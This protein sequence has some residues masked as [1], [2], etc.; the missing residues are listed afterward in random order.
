MANAII[1]SIKAREIIDSRGNPTVEVDCVTDDGVFTD[2]VPSGASAGAKEAKELRDG[3]KRYGGKGVL[4]AIKNVNEVISQAIVGEDASDQAAIDNFLI[5]L[6]G[7]PDKSKLGANAILAVSMAACRA[8]AANLKIPLYEHIG[9][10]S[11][12]KDFFMPRPCFNIIN[13]GAH[14]ENGLDFQEFMIVPQKES[15]AENVQAGSETYYQLKKLI[16][17]SYSPAAAN[18]GDEG[19]FAPPMDAP[20]IALGLIT[21]AIQRSGYYDKIGII[22]DAAASQF[23]NQT[24]A[25]SYYKTMMGIFED[26]EFLNYYDELVNQYPII[27]LEDPFAEEDWESFASINKKYG[28]RIMIIGDDLLA[29]NSRYI[30]KAKTKE[31]C[32]AALLKLNQIGTVTE[33]IKSAKLAQSYG[34]KTII[35]HRSGETTDD[36]IADLAV[37]IGADFIKAGAPARGERTVKYNRLLKIEENLIK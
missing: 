22:I 26:G 32:N 12:R 7:T 1:R 14:A 19:G 15:F 13:G 24:D 31:A 17:Q 11:G 10:L 36:F 34:W 6:D 29:S 37:G 27:G 16:K 23:Y 5:V 25:G 35:S 4:A 3:G 30:E 9:S 21:K 28:N 18:V 2:S 8:G 33:L 20:E